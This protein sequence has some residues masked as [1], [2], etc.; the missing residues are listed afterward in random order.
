MPIC[1]ICEQHPGHIYDSFGTEL[2]CRDCAGS[3]I[4]EMVADFARG[5]DE[6]IFSK[7]KK[8]SMWDVI[9]AGAK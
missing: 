6:A 3:E 4:G 1:T 9:S 8:L 5:L 2:V 7:P